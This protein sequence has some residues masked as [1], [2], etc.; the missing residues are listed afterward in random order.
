[1][2]R[3]NYANMGKGYLKFDDFKNLVENNPCIQSIE[4]SMS[5]E[6]FLNPELIDIIKFANKNNI[7]LTAY[8]GVN[9]NNISDKMIESL[10]KYNFKGLTVSIDGASNET[11][12]QYRRK[13]NFDKVIGNIKKLNKYKTLYKS[14]Y[15]NLRWQFI[16]MNHNDHE[17][18]KAKEMSKE[19]K[20]EKIYF[21]LPWD[22]EYIPK[23]VDFVEKETDL[24]FQKS[25]YEKYKAK[26]KNPNKH[27]LCY[28]LW[29]QP[30]FNWDG[31]FL[32][33]CCGT[34]ID[35]GINI[36]TQG[37]EKSLKSPKLKYMKKVLQGKCEPDNSI[38][39]IHCNTYKLMKESGDFIKL[40]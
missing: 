6:I 9:F 24:I 16:L 32:G 2:R 37:Y 31:R 3:D 34:Y 10:V 19:L 11:Y 29:K 14:K 23:N 5:G 25:T 13:G 20:I 12:S 28:Q 33:C 27:L 38:P 35:L 15:P 36:F 7:K 21:L 17:I 4:L 18:L 26:H 22:G 8:N 30:Q 40:H 1:M 39:C